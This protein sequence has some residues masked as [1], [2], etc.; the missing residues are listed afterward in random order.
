MAYTPLLSLVLL[1][2]VTNA[3]FTPTAKPVP[4]ELVKGFRAITVG[5]GKKFLGYIAGPECEGRGTGEPGFQKAMEF[6]AK[7][8]KDFG[9]KPIMPDGTFFQYQDFWRI[10]A[11]TEKMV[12]SSS[13]YTAKMGEFTI[14]GNGTVDLPA[15]E[16]VYV[17]IPKDAK[18]LTGF[19]PESVKGKVVFILN[20]S[21]TRRIERPI[22]Q[23]APA[24]FV[25]L[26]EEVG[27]P[28]WR[29]SRQKP[30]ASISTPRLE[31]KPSV[32]EKM[33]GIKPDTAD[34]MTP[35]EG[36]VTLKA[37]VLVEP[38]KVANV[39]AKL[40]GSD[41]VLKDEFIGVGA[42][43]DHLGNRNGVLYPGADD[44]GSGSTA[45][46]QV[47]KSLTRNPLKPKRTVIFMAFYGEEM[48]LL[49]SSFFVDNPPVK[50]DNMVAELQMD[51]VGRRSDGAQNGDEKRIDKAEDNI[52]TIRLVGSKRISTAL[53][54]I[55]L[56]TNEHVGWKFKYDAE[57]VYTRS[58]HFNFA[59][60]GIPIAFFFTGFHPDYHQPSDTIEK[61]D[62]N[63]IANTA[64]LVYLTIH[65]LGGY[66]GRLPK[67]VV[68]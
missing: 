60:K 25:S 56:E 1:A 64:K 54:K 36:Q 67:D 22:L 19:K 27:I 66:E 14:S 17:H 32:F 3:Q 51:M 10:K 46:L 48:G 4:K 5:D 58:D 68:K 49:G 30:S 59:K 13:K 33:T 8:F 34:L 2:S 7:N 55:I 9:L 52:D 18:E 41:P 45:L 42:H 35:I 28:T 62:F 39:V 29:G 43:L 38:V 20:E 16:A 31:V 40:E 37:D 50:L 21:E 61:I 65:K 44:D 23:G 15:A 53:D 63:K 57:D 12:L 47:A 26:N 6:M 24:A 11:N